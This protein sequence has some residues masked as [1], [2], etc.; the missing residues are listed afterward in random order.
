[1]AD[2]K[3]L[4]VAVTLARM[5]P[6]Q[7]PITAMLWATKAMT[8]WSPALVPVESAVRKLA[9]VFVTLKVMPVDQPPMTAMVVATKDVN[10]VI[11][12][13]SPAL[14]FVTNVPRFVP[15]VSSTASSWVNVK[16]VVMSPETIVVSTA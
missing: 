1:M 9:I 15:V 13:G 7:P 4:I 5:P 12:I 11:R 2:R 8:D 6:L 10:D 16:P 14:A 3:A